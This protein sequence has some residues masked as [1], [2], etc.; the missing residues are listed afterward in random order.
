M[1]ILYVAGATGM[2][3]KVVFEE[4][5]RKGYNVKPLSLG[6]DISKGSI[7][8]NCAG[9]I[10]E[11]K[12]QGSDMVYANAVLP[13][14][15]AEICEERAS[16]FI[17]ISTDCVFRG[18]NRNP[19]S[20]KMEPNPVEI[21]GASKAMGEKILWE[22]PNILIT[23]V[24]TSFIGL[25][26]GLM[27]WFVN[28]AKNKT[29]VE[30]YQN[31]LWTGST[32]WEAS[33]GILEIAEKNN[34]ALIEHLSTERVWSKNEV[35]QRVNSLLDLGVNIESVTSPRINR[36]LIPTTVIRDLDDHFVSAELWEKFRS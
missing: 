5:R 17:H 7:V 3:G 27:K 22:Y 15:I 28:S 19:I 33:R 8:I 2:L 21:Y 20:N 32:V 30:G 10:P 29:S 36:A 1:A 11:G 4:A 23:V 25:T 9:A 26:H 6:S 12:R 13:F 24:R 31:V 14:E 35:L 16:R 34:P 18:N